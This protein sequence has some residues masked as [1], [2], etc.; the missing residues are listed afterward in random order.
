MKELKHLIGKAYKD[1]VIDEI[2]TWAQ[3]R[4]YSINIVPTNVDNIDIDY[5]RLN[6]WVDFDTGLIT[7]FTKS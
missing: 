2:N 7:K 4:G 5:K 1:T 3:D 6:V